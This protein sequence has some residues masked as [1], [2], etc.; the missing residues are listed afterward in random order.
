MIDNPKDDAPPN[1]QEQERQKDEAREVAK[2]AAN[3]EDCRRVL[4][5]SQYRE[6]YHLPRCGDGCD[7]CLEHH[8]AVPQDVTA[9]ALRVLRFA[10]SACDAHISFTESELITAYKG[11]KLQT[12]SKKGLDRLP[13]SAAGLEVDQTLIERIVSYLARRDG[14]RHFEQTHGNGYNATYLRVRRIPFL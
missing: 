5:L 14:L 6:R 9:E 1:P 7:N 4:I 11:R 2:F 8:D 10:S 3:R 13:L 12:L